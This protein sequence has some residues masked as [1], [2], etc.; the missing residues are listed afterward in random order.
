MFALEQGCGPC[1]N[2]NECVDCSTERCND[3][4]LVKKNFHTCFADQRYYGEVIF[5]ACRRGVETCFIEGDFKG[6]CGKCDPNSNCVDCK[7]LNCNTIDKYRETFF[8]YIGRYDEEYELLKLG[9]AC[10]K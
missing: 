3:Y 8:C 7:G 5:A 6:G 9:N 4:E 10:E 2:N 1:D